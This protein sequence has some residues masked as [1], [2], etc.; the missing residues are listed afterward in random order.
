MARHGLRIARA[1]EQFLQQAS[2]AACWA[3]RA[4]LRDFSPTRHTHGASH[5]RFA[6]IKARRK[7]RKH[8]KAQ[9]QHAQK[10]QGRRF[11]YVW[12]PLKAIL[13]SLR[14]LPTCFALLSA[15]LSTLP[16]ALLPAL[17]PN[18]LRTLCCSA[19]RVCFS[20]CSSLCLLR[21][22]SSPRSSV[23]SSHS[24]EAVLR[25]PFPGLE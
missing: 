18:L 5:R 3:P 14:L 6:G 20:F 1:C 24:A 11:A 8:T 4:W 10:K 16:S 23:C 21:S 2:S 17:I 7:Y 25:F 12:V 15:L 9:K 13:F 19:P 22:P